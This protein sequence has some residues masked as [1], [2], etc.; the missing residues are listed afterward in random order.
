MDEK[1]WCSR[2]GPG[3]LRGGGFSEECGGPGE[4]SSIT[5]LHAGPLLYLPAAG[6]TRTAQHP[7]P[8][9][10]AHGRPREEPAHGP[11]PEHTSPVPVLGSEGINWHQLAPVRTPWHQQ[12]EKEEPEWLPQMSE[13]NLGQELNSWRK[14]SLG[15]QEIKHEHFT[16][17]EK[18][19]LSRGEGGRRPNS[20]VKGSRFPKARHCQCLS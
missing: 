20:R 17:G 4:G 12:L 15:P 7:Q 14:E 19:D 3:G 2:E 9:A 10:W 13:R 18:E 6:G 1:G 16:K 8:S 11:G 5:V